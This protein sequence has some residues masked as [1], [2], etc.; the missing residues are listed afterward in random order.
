MPSLCS[1]GSVLPPGSAVDS[2]IYFTVFFYS[3]KDKM[4][5]A[6]MTR[7]VHSAPRPTTALTV[8]T[9]HLSRTPTITT[10]PDVL[11]LKKDTWPEDFKAKKIIE[12]AD[13]KMKNAV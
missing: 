9:T 6:Q 5:M 8:D 13:L 10:S 7:N 3:N 4:W 2:K 1:S 12:S 11:A